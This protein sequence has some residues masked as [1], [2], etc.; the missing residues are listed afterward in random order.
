MSVVELPRDDEALP[1]PEHLQSAWG[2]LRR[3]V[4]GSPELRRGLGLTVIVSLGVTV[5]SLVTP[6]LIQMV[7]DHG[8]SPFNASYIAKIC[9][10]AL[11]LVVVAFV[12]AREAGRRL[13]A[14]AENAMMQLRVRTFAHIHSL[15]IADQSGSRP[16]STRCSSSW[17]GAASRGSSR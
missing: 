7:F 11:V 8:F 16:T 5:V 6:V 9:A 2:V 15:S 3:G 13:V 14:A 12:A 10:V 17:S 1:I 4:L